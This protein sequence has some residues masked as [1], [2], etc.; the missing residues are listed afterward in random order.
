MTAGTNQPATASARRWIGARL[1][2]ASATS[3]TMRA[4]MVSRPL[5]NNSKSTNSGKRA[6]VTAS[7]TLRNTGSACSAT[8][9]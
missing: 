2:C 5:V 7:I 8:L 1:R 6:Y 4:S 9:P 3:V